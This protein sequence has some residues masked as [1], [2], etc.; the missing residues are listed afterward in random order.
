MQ[1]SS[2]EPTYVFSEEQ[3]IEKSPLAREFLSKRTI[4]NEAVLASDN[5][6]IKRFYNLDHNAYLEGELPAKT[7]ELIGLSVS[8][9]LRCEGCINYH[10]IQSYRLGASRKE[11]EE[12][13]DISLLIG[14]SI[15]VPALRKAY[16]IL[17]QL[18]S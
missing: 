13:L 5:R 8:A 11:I 1:K 12:S 10:T 2:R 7:K 17:D 14:G 15:V 16:L 4:E 9:A 18:Y 6:F 3:V